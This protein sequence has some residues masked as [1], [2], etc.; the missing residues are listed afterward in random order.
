MAVWKY[1]PILFWIIFEF[2]HIS[3]F[4]YMDCLLTNA[5]RIKHCC[6][7]SAAPYKVPY[8]TQLTN[9]GFVVHNRF[10]VDKSFAIFTNSNY[11]YDVFQI[12]QDVDTDF[13]ILFHKKLGCTATSWWLTFDANNNIATFIDLLVYYIIYF[14][15]L[16]NS[17]SRSYQWAYNDYNCINIILDVD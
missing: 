3:L 16:I 14:Y 15:V 8:V 7:N 17:N 10:T 6:D 12:D 4:E 5:F 13:Y 9:K 2:W 1:I 11:W